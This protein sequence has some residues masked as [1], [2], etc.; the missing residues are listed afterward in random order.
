MKEIG[1]YLK[2]NLF[3]IKQNLNDFIV[4]EIIDNEIC[5]DKIILSGSDIESELKILKLNYIKLKNNN[6][7]KNNLSH[8][9]HDNIDHEND[10]INHDNEDNHDNNINHDHEN[11][12]H[13]N[14]NHDHD[15]DDHDHGNDNNY[16]F[17]VIEESK[18]I[19][20]FLYKKLSR[21]IKYILSY[22][23]LGIKIT[24]IDL[25]KNDKDDNNINNLN[26]KN[27]LNNNIN[28]IKND[29]TNIYHCILKKINSNTEYITNIICK[30]LNSKVCFAGNKDR[31]AITYQKISIESDYDNLLKVENKCCLGECRKNFIDQYFIDNR[32]FIDYKNF[33]FKIYNFESKGRHLK[34]GDL[35]GNRFKIKIKHEY[36]NHNYNKCDNK[37][38]K[39]NNQNLSFE[40]RIFPN[41]F[42]P[43]RFG[44]NKNHEIGK[45]ISEDKY[46]EALKVINL[47]NHNYKND[48][49]KDD[50]SKDDNTKDDNF[51]DD[52][53]KDDNEDNINKD[54]KKD[55]NKD[56]NK[57]DN[58]KDDKK[59]D[60]NKDNNKDDINKDNI[61]STTFPSHKSIHFIKK[62]LLTLYLHS[63]QSYIFNLE[64]S[65]RLKEWIFKGVGLVIGD[66]VEN[67][68]VNCGCFKLNSQSK[69]KRLRNFNNGD[70]KELKN[71]FKKEFKNKF[72]NDNQFDNQFDNE[73][74]NNNFDNNNYFDNNFDNNLK[75][76]DFDFTSTVFESLPLPTKR[77][78]FKN[79]IQI[80]KSNINNFCIHQLCLP[81]RKV[82]WECGGF[83][84][85]F[86]EPM[87]VKITVNNDNINTNNIN[88][89]N[90]NNENIFND[91]KEFIAEFDLPS[92]SFATV[93]LMF[94]EIKFYK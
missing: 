67:C 1:I 15:N 23:K 72:N 28:K 42:G 51:K 22:D 44:L 85:A 84:R 35:S 24:P 25:C 75:F 5:D 50:N 58:N 81:I 47:I 12:D 87:N 73:F 31:H 40:L 13:Y 91:E 56:D 9:Y 6:Y 65:F 86:V 49:S 79:L 62:H 94:S 60:I 27:N 10:N 76:I 92:G 77:R 88:N 54:D 43:Q 93:A 89:E 53:N 46:E 38:E 7:L 34:L 41:F 14:I 55:N 39:Y 48:N 70:N 19:R 2:T 69:K 17:V 29:N 3:K 16:S 63:Y 64:L 80:D 30:K 52:N 66:F 57:D 4:K 20:Q 90:I 78:R 18:Q 11:K 32:N 59:D 45:L 8:K 36:T 68:F 61:K 83:R 82:K 33:H 74:N 37:F 26:N 21:F 71:E